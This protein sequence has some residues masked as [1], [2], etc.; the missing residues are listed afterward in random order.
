MP[1]GLVSGRQANQSI[2]RQIDASTHRRW[3][4]RVL[5]IL[6]TAGCA[7]EP[8]PA[9]APAA[10]P[11]NAADLVFGPAGDRRFD[12]GVV[13][14][15]EDR[16]L[17]H[18]YRLVNHSDS[19]VRILEVVNAKPCCGQ[20]EPVESNTLEPGE[21][22]DIKVTVRAGQTLGPVQ[23]RVLV[24]TDLGEPATLEYWTVVEVI[25]R[26]RLDEVTEKLAP[27]FPGHSAQRRFVVYAHALEG[28]RGLE[29]DDSTVNATSG[30]AWEGPARRTQRADG[31]VEWSRPL[32]I[33]L[34]A[35]GDP[36]PRTETITVLDGERPALQR[37]LDWEVA[38]CLKADPP[39]L[40]AAVASRMEKR[41]IVRSV[42]GRAFRITSIG[43]EAPGVSAKVEEDEPRAAHVVRVAIEPEADGQ[44]RSGKLVIKTDHPGQAVVVVGVLIT[45]PNAPAAR[46]AGGETS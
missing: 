23:H 22:L 9:L 25:P 46:P 29:L 6:A 34:T 26:V 19:P 28:E 43:V 33:T 3:T 35:E 24:E 30:L 37:R 36:G 8:R 11:S 17:K 1:V 4:W 7:E 31:V 13:V 39:G 45:A 42:D 38:S 40:I 21:G 10:P 32:S 27:L 16:S 44:G 2:S 18:E 14:G 5:V 12:F 41:V 20:V 15:G